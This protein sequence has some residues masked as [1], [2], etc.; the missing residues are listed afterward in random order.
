MST[1]QPWTGDVLLQDYS[2]F[3]CVTSLWSSLPLLTDI[4]KL[5][6]LVTQ[7]NYCFWSWWKMSLSGT[8][9]QRIHPAHLVTPDWLPEGPSGYCGPHYPDEQAQG[10]G[11]SYTGWRREVRTVTWLRLNGNVGGVGVAWTHIIAHRVGA[12]WTH[13]VLQ[14]A[15]SSCS[16]SDWRMLGQLQ[17]KHMGWAGL[18]G[19]VFLYNVQDGLW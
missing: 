16:Y 18:M 2:P 4:L 6:Q 10:G 8:G 9:K 5:N 12:G 14:A 17:C 7:S 3:S 13:T 15:D 1:P 19:K 11:R